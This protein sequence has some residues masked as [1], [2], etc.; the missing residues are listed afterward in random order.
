MSEALSFLAGMLTSWQFVLFISLACLGA[1]LSYFSM[2]AAYSKLE[3]DNENLYA[4]YLST[5]NE[6]SRLK[7]AFPVV[8]EPATLEQLPATTGQNPTL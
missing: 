2:Y 5:A 4:D 8:S 7:K 1:V 3:A 6:L